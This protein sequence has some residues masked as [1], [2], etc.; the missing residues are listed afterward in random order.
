MT[1]TYDANVGD[2]GRSIPVSLGSSAGTL[3]S[4]TGV[5]NVLKPRSGELA[6]WTVGNGTPGNGFDNSAKT[7]TYTATVAAD[8]TEVG[9][10]AIS[11]TYTVGSVVLTSSVTW[12]RVGPKPANLR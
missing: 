10:Y 12:L 4:A 5:L 11:C 2:V 3:T 9:N 1:I 8:L 7:A 6:S